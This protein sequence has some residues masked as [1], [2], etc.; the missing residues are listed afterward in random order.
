VRSLCPEGLASEDVHVWK[1]LI[2]R[3]AITLVDVSSSKTL[4]ECSIALAEKIEHQ[5]QCETG[6]NGR[7][8]L[9][10]FSG[11]AQWNGR[12]QPFFRRWGSIKSVRRIVEDQDCV[13]RVGLEPVLS[14]N[15]KVGTS[16]S[17]CRQRFITLVNDGGRIPSL[18]RH[19]TL[20]TRL[21]VEV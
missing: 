2:E 16:L 7:A 11:R 14:A 18:M 20:I 3:L 19:I 6:A 9:Y 4:R 8:V 13:A 12:Q 1:Y 10:V 21:S 17:F 15:S 5:T